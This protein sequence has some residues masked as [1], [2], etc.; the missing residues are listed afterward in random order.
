MILDTLECFYLDASSIQVS[1]GIQEK[2]DAKREC[3]FF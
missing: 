3:S 2:T 1:C